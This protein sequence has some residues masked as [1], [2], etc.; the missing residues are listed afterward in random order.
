M[1][2][3]RQTLNARS[4]PPAFSLIEVLVV[5]GTVSIVLAMLIPGLSGA[6]E[7]GR[8][9]MCRVHL[10]ELIRANGYYAGDHYDRFCPGAAD[11]LVNRHR[12]HGVRPKV[13]SPFEGKHGPLAPYLD[14]EKLIRQC[15]T[16]PA[17]EAARI[18]GGFERNAGGY[19]YSGVY[20][21]AAT[22]HRDNDEV[23]VLDDRIGARSSDVRRPADTIMFADTAFAASALIEYS[24]VEP[25]FQPMNP[26]QRADPSI[27]YR[28][29]GQANVGWCDG[30]V[31]S[32]RR[33]LTW[34]SGF[35][36]ADPDKL[37]L[38]WFGHDDNNGFFDLR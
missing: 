2:V 37:Q 12:W 35:Y 38:G 10:A 9:T 32:R 19:G 15:P 16:F 5:M 30:H 29:V 8:A 21:G 1:N 28:H 31:D 22:L 34:K 7:Q 26:T 18:S 27:H 6:R 13:G 25:R 36:R 3:P 33:T 24:F 17:E 23:T 14:A 11:F 20:V 4:V